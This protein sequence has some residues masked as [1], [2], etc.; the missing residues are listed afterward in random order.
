[1]NT[2]TK[3]PLPKG[4]ATFVAR[5]LSV[6]VSVSKDRKSEIHI[7]TCLEATGASDELVKSVMR[8]M[9]VVDDAWRVH[10]GLPVHPHPWPGPVGQPV[11]QPGTAQ[12]H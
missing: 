12:R 5:D 2:K 3:Q 4:K 1:M 8:A 7:V 6:I 11:A 10:L 9:Q